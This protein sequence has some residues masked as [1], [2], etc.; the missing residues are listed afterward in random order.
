VS[1]LDFRT[2]KIDALVEKKRE[3]IEK[4]KE[5][6]KGLIYRAV[7]EGVTGNVE[8][9]DTGLSFVSRV[10][11]HWDM[12]RLK[13]MATIKNGVDYKHVEVESYEDGY[14]VYGSGGMFR[15]ANEYLYDG[16]S[17]LFGRKGT[18]DKPLFVHGKFW[19]VDTMFYSVLNS[20][21]LP[22]YM[23]YFSLGMEFNYLAT[24]TALPSITQ[25]DLSNYFVCSPPR[26]EQQEIALYL[27]R[28]T[29]KIDE[30]IELNE[31][32][33]VKLLEYRSSLITHVLSGNSDIR[34]FEV[35]GGSK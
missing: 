27:D 6:R 9:K 15:K 26:D 29:Q 34:K 20:S 3:L 23:Y 16:E 7:S 22:R 30:M 10:P 32:A 18:I 8:M 19:T 35:H 13:F 12:L 2:N 5:S 25:Q 4:L 1:F 33:I 14:P 31:K 24:Q 21:V 11:A 17:V 28:E